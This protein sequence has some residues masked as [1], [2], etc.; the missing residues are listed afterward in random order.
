M[1]V[2]NLILHENI[3][4]SLQADEHVLVIW[5]KGPGGG[6]SL[7]N[8]I[9]GSVAVVLQAIHQTYKINLCKQVPLKRRR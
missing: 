8:M 2:F 3:K 5:L 6:E 7:E 4:T 1:G 9:P